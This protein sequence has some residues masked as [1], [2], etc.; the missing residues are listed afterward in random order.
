ME[1]LVSDIPA[2]D[3]KNNNLFYSEVFLH[4]PLQ[5]FFLNLDPDP[6]FTRPK[7]IQF[8]K[9]SSLFCLTLGAMK[10]LPLWTS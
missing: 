10:F 9:S 7:K 1:S 5:D 8:Q 4:G 6:G 2:G 3:G